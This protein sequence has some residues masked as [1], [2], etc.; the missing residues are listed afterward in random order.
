MA[1]A[2]SLLAGFDA[3]QTHTT[4]RLARPAADGSLTVLAEGEGPG[5]SHLAAQQ[6]PEHFRA[7][8]RLSLEAARAAL[9]QG[10]REP[11]AA[12]ALGASGIEQGTALQSLAR[13]L[14]ATTLAL[15]EGAVL[16]TG[17][18]RT[19]LR[20]AL[21]STPGI[22]VISG[23]GCICLGRNSAGEERR[24]GGWGWLLDGAGSA[25]D[26]G[27]DGLGLSLRMAD[28]RCADTPLRQALWQALGVQPSDPAGA[29][30][31]KA[32]VVATGFGAAGFAAL[33]PVVHQFAATGDCQAASILKRSALALAEMVAAVASGLNLVQPPVVGLGGA[34]RHLE[35]FRLQFEQ[36]LVKGGISLRLSEP[37]GDAA[38]G[39]LALALEQL[40]L[41]RR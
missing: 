17:D 1:E 41:S 34:L 23:T 3:G 40:A 32:L 33:A 9:P 35:Q 19:A 8:L 24:A 14:A 16:A 10:R 25:M 18:E 13:E 22:V 38:S 29:Q 12:A 30:A 36:A 7:A 2:A 11:L 27:R 6:G 28:G 26:I 31:I 15:P 20:G 37:Q 39:A 21:G 5:V 4:C